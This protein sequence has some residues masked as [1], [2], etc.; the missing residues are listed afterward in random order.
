[1]ILHF[2]INFLILYILVNL[3]SSAEYALYTLSIT[4][5]WFFLLIAT[6]GMEP[7]ITRLLTNEQNKSERFQKIISTSQLILIF[8]SLL[9]FIFLFISADFFE[10]LYKMP[11][12]AISLKSIS[13]F[14]LFSNMINYFEIVLRS[15]NKFKLYA[16][17]IISLNS[18]KLI[19]VILNFYKIIP[20]YTIFSIFALIS[21]IH[22][23]ILMIYFQ[24]KYKS[25]N[26]LFSIDLIL[27]K[28]I[29]KS[30][31]IV[32]LPLL[33]S[34]I[35]QKFNIFILAYYISS[36]ELSIYYIACRF[37]DLISLPVMILNLVILPIASK[38]MQN[39]KDKNY[40][41]TRLFN[42]FL[43]MGLFYM[44][45]ATILTFFLS[46][47]FIMILF[48]LEYIVSSSYVRIFL[49][50][51]NIR[52]I[53]VVGPNFLYAEN[54]IKTVF[55]LTAVT[56]ISILLL[57]LVTIPFLYSY[58]AIFSIILPQSIYLIYSVFL[59][60]KRNKV[61]LDS[62]LLSTLSKFIGSGLLSLI[63]TYVIHIILKF[64]LSNFI[65]L[66]IFCSIFVILYLLLTFIM[67]AIDSKILKSFLKETKESFN[68]KG[69]T[70]RI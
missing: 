19:I 58:A 18:M 40:K 8:L 22:F 5:Y 67:K 51:L 1:M 38:Y 44:I 42:I 2:I 37:V 60:K 55:K 4:F 34:Y 66:A 43:K 3:F 50:Y 15:F 27:S 63:I 41:I 9:V 33:F 20:I 70:N 24:V 21:F 69:K 53:G 6:F 17:S 68:L 52:I 57:S 56:A 46:D 14:L 54:Q 12:L 35:S 23:I 28:E 62:N 61:K 10:F 65:Q 31:F 7:L 47:F 30:A 16:I 29:L 26:H 49:F 11:N 25:L 32:F 48:P 36:S 45:P 39:Q 13:F 59:V 64:N